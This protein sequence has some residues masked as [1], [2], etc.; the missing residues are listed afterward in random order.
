MHQ[1]IDHTYLKPE[2]TFKEIDTLMEEAIRYQFK[3]VCIQPCFVSYA[4]DQLAKETVLVCTVIGFPLGVNT[5]STKVYE[6]KKA[7]EDGADEIDMVGNLGYIKA[8]NYQAYQAEVQAIKALCQDKV[9]KVILETGA[10]TDE[11]IKKA[12]QAALDG[13]ADYLKTSTGFGPGQATVE[14]VK[15]MASVAQGKGVKASGGVRTYE[16]ATAMIEA[17]ATRIGTSNGVAIITGHTAQ[18]NY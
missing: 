13:G 18:E 5:L 9:L 7:L 15:L 12:S 4:A 11:E 2:G 17:G 8:N 3:S 14:A 6:T 16:D 10:L 1:Y